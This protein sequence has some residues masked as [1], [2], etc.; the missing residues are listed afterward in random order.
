MT[1]LLFFFILSTFGCLNVLQAGANPGFYPV[2][3]SKIPSAVQS[4]SEAV[5]NFEF[6][7]WVFDLQTA[8][9]KAD[10]TYLS[11]NL[12]SIFKSPYERDK[13]IP[14]VEK[15]RKAERYCV[16]WNRGSAILVNDGRTLLTALHTLGYY[17]RDNFSSRDPKS[18]EKL[19]ATKFPIRLYDQQGR[20]LT[21]DQ[22][23]F[24]E[25]MAQI[26]HLSPDTR[27]SLK[28]ENAEFDYVI[29][30][31]DREISKR[32]LQ[33]QEVAGDDENKKE[34][35]Y[36]LGY[37]RPT[38]DRVVLGAP[39]SD[40]QSLR[41]TF[42]ERVTAK[43][44]ERFRWDNTNR[45]TKKLK[46][47]LFIHFEA[48][49]VSGQSGGAI[50]D[51]SGRLRGVFVMNNAD[52]NSGFKEN[53]ISTGYNVNY[54]LNDETLPTSIQSSK[55]AAERKLT[56]IDTAEEKKIESQ[57]KFRSYRPSFPNWQRWLKMSDR[58]FT[59]RYTVE[60]PRTIDWNG[61]PVEAS[62]LGI[63]RCSFTMYVEYVIK[64]NADGTEGLF[65]V[66][67]TERFTLDTASA[68]SERFTREQNESDCANNTDIEDILE[69]IPDVGGS[70]DLPIQW[71]RIIR[72]TA[73]EIV[74][75]VDLMGATPSKIYGS[76]KEYLYEMP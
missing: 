58:V 4:A 66:P 15:C 73:K 75:G 10:F 63:L 62:Q 60:H 54:I 74:F 5:L 53:V 1:K 67:R 49:S 45:K 26:K 61:Q 27:Q 11:N 43:K 2:T 6:P 37:P 9:G 34:E 23:D 21:G 16:I 33:M 50:V 68:T 56:L 30:T 3:D 8:N 25:T 44:R 70:R 69:K 18:L 52:T 47:R 38:K 40:G 48:D 41:V 72:R 76:S 55:P 13:V 57:E 42:G 24:G 17:L 35:F 39:D 65:F 12:D 31:F 36:L 22:G 59:D 46:Q 64:R 7:L 51:V 28:Y 32:P 29:L 14:Q 71:G 19:M 20:L